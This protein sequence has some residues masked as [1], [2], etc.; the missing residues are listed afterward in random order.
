MTWSVPESWWRRSE[1]VHGRS[2]KPKRSRSVKSKADVDGFVTRGSAAFRAVLE[3]EATPIELHDAGVEFL[4]R[5]HDGGRSS[6]LGTAVAWT[7]M[8]DQPHS[9]MREPFMVALIDRYGGAFAAE[10]A[11]LAAGFLGRHHP[12]PRG[13]QHGSA[14][15]LGYRGAS[16]LLNVWIFEPHS[17]VRS[18]LAALPAS[19]YRAAVDRVSRLRGRSLAQDI[20]ISFLLPTENA[21]WKQDLARVASLDYDFSA[22]HYSLALLSCVDTAHDVETLF[23]HCGTRDHAVW[24][25]GQRMNLVC[26]MAVNVGPGAESY[27]GELFDGNVSAQHKKRLAMMLAEFGTDEG[28]AE[29]LARAE[30]KYVEPALL[31]AMTLDPARASRMLPGAT[32]T[33]PERLMHEHLTLHPPEGAEPKQPSAEQERVRGVLPTVLVRPPWHRE[34][35]VEPP[36][37]IGDGPT[38]SPLTLNWTDGEREQYRTSGDSYTPWTGGGRSWPA[39]VAEIRTDGY[40]GLE[41]LAYAPE[42]LVRPLLGSLPVPRSVWRP[43]RDLRRILGRFD[44]AAVEFVVDVVAAKPART[45]HVLMPVGGSR[46]VGLMTKWLASKTL[47]ETAQT[48]FDRHIG[49]ASGDLVDSAVGPL[50]LDRTSARRALHDLDRRGHREA[51][52]HAAGERGMAVTSGVVDLLDTDPLLDLPS[53][54]PVLPSWIEPALL[55]PVTTHDGDALPSAEVHNLC[56]MLALSRLDHTYAGLDIVLPALDSQSLERFVWG[57]FERWQRA[58]YPEPQGWVLEALAIGG[59]DDTVRSLTQLLLRWPLQSAHRRAE[60]GLAVLADIGTDAALAALWRI[61]QGLRFPALTAKAEAHIDRVADELGLTPDELADRLVPDFGLAADGSLDVDYGGRSFTVRLDAQLRPVVFDHDGRVRKSLPR[62]S[63]SDGDQ[64]RESYRQFGRF[65]KELAP[66]ATELVQRFERAMITQRLWPMSQVRA[67]LLTHPVTWEVCRS[68]IWQVQDGPTF[69]C[70]DIRTAVDVRGGNLAI[71]DDARVSVA[72]PVVVDDALASWRAAVDEHIGLQSFDQIDRGVFGAD[73]HARL[74]TYTD[75]KT[76]TRQLLGLS[77]RGW[78]R[79]A[80]QDKGAQ[81]ALHKYRGNEVLATMLV[82]PGFNAANPVQWEQQR[83][84]DIVVAPGGLGRIEQSE[85]VRDLDSITVTEF[86]GGEPDLQEF[87]S[88]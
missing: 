49:T 74:Q 80:P 45:A 78:K 39:R 75:S 6:A 14:K 44:S 85:L 86:T 9:A 34:V 58:G 61:A 70:T 76:D 21:W 47:R 35:A 54:M 48:W 63:S 1:A 38:V 83:I 81:I 65:R 69:R 68:L 22:V 57:L 36:T 62:P 16:D 12:D 5:W 66:V 77:S 53:T 29:L 33:V 24:M 13:S 32:G 71:D 2:P 20:V 42:P 43:Q 19:E 8:T 28:F 37:V 31:H 25:I 27:L 84:I 51:I 67:H 10:T 59:G 60:V 4:D 73:L 56:L 55:P 87:D 72:H 23:Q 11:V 79:E 46:V 7:V 88:I 15:S 40:W 17:R 64:A 18:A 50:G 82:Y 26:S 30:K 3:H 41:T 52:L